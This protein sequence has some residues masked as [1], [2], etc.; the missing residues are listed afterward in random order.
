M[1]QPKCSAVGQL[2]LSN[3]PLI[4]NCH[5]VSSTERAGVI[6]WTQVQRQRSVY[7]MLKINT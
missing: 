7:T 4:L 6:Q 2:S 5:T 1:T 3:A